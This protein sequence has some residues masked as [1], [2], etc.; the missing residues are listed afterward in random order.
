MAAVDIIEASPL[1]LIHG[2][3]GSLSDPA[4]RKPLAP[5]PVFAPKLL[6]YGELADINP[7]DVTI[8]NQAEHVHKAILQQFGTTPVHLL[9]HSVG[10][11][12]ATLLIDRYPDQILSFISVEG[13]FT[14][15][16]AFWS[17]QIA[18]MPLAQVA[19]MLNEF[20]ADPAG[21]LNNNGISPTTQLIERAMAQLSNQSATTIQAMSHSVIAVTGKTTYTEVLQNIFQTKPVHL[22]AGERTKKNWDVPKWARKLAASDH[23][24]PRVGHMMMLEDPLAF[25][26]LLHHILQKS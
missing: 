2:L 21:W 14:L 8:S 4:I 16:D 5:R 15:Q 13:N 26:E 25:G 18:Q 22:L 23:T 6:G 20:R 17:A 9:G 12:I 19:A 11:A 24:M 3:I 7:S 1:V 10:G